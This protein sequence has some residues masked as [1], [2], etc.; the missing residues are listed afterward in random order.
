MSLRRRGF[1]GVV[2]RVDTMRRIGV[3]GA[4]LIL[5]LIISV[6]W[7]VQPASAIP[8]LSVKPIS[9]T[10]GVTEITVD[11]AGLLPALRGLIR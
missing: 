8:T 11:G 10:A 4:V 3:F 1:D 9:G 2:I 6:V 5:G 7:P